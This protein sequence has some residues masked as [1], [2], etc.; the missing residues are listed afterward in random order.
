[1]PLLCQILTGSPVAPDYFSKQCPLT[2]YPQELSDSS[3]LKP[4]K[5]YLAPLSRSVVTTGTIIQRS[6]LITKIQQRYGRGKPSSSSDRR[7][8][9]LQRGS[10]MS[11][12]VLRKRVCTQSEPL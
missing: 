9:R 5:F 2:L 10:R 6:Y 4:I 8:A 1:T 7:V 3:D 12:E 11:V